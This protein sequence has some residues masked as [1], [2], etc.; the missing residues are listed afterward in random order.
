[1]TKALQ[2]FEIKPAYEDLAVPGATSLQQYLKQVH[3]MNVLAAI[4]VITATAM[5]HWTWT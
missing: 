5:Q 3:E 1:M 2:T 4:Q